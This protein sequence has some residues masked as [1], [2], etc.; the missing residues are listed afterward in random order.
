MPST[1]TK[2]NIDLPDY[3]MHKDGCHSAK[4]PLHCW[5]VVKC[6]LLTCFCDRL[7]ASA[8]IS[9]PQGLFSSMSMLSW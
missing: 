3:M 5:S 9:L 8:L 2:Q 7:V 6:L 1:I 4:R